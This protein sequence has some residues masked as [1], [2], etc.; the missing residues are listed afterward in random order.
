MERILVSNRGEIARRVFRTARAL[1]IETVAVYSEPDAGAP[2]V[3]EADIAIALRGATSAETYLDV[4]QILDVYADRVPMQ[5]IPATA[6]FRR[7]PA[8]PSASRPQA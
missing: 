7:M 6:S 2:F 3:R 1:G 5:S 4:E 8:S